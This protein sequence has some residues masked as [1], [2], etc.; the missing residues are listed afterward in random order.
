METKAG[1][2][3]KGFN[4][5]SFLAQAL[6]TYESDAIVDT[7][8]D[9]SL[10]K[11]AQSL[12]TVVLTAQKWTT[13][14]GA[15]R[16]RADSKLA[17]VLAPQV[18]AYVDAKKAHDDAVAKLNAELEAVA[19]PLVDQGINPQ[20]IRTGAVVPT[21]SGN[22]NGGGNRLTDEQ[23]Q[24]IRDYVGKNPN[25]KPQEVADHTGLG[26]RVGA[27]RYVMTKRLA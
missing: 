15:V 26:E 2:T 9:A 21:K 7:A 6:K 16:A 27:V 17:E 5:E 24:A 1:S 19:K 22:G 4:A 14:I 12:K 3:A 11:G 23:V 18:K 8:L 25:A 13:I 10:P 20:R